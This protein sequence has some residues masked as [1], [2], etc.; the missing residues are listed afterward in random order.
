MSPKWRKLRMRLDFMEISPQI[1][2]STMTTES[3]LLMEWVNYTNRKGNWK[4]P[5]E[6]VWRH[7]KYCK[8]LISSCVGKEM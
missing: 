1:K 4:T 6:S 3:D 5:K 2:K 7:N 8:K